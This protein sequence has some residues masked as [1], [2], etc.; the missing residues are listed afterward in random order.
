MK[1]LNVLLAFLVSIALG[2]AI[3]EGG[4]R[5]L[6]RGPDPTPL[7][8]FDPQT[9]WSKRADFKVTR[10]SPEYRATIE[11]NALGLRDDPMA[12]PAKPAGIYRVLAIGDSFT[13]GFS[14]EREDLFVDLLEERW[15]AEGRAVEVV[16]AG[17][18]AWDTAQQAAWLEQNIAEYEPDLVLLFPYE[19]D[20]YWNSQEVYFSAGG[21]RSKP[22]YSASGERVNPTLTDL[23]DR[24]WIQDW[25][26]TQWLYEPDMSAA[27]AHAF[28]PSGAGR[29]IERELGPLLDSPPTW[30]NEVRQHTVGALRAV[31]SAAESVGAEVAVFP[32]PSAALFDEDWI[33]RYE[34]RGLA[35]TRWSADRPVDTFLETAKTAGLEAID[36]RPGLR[37]AAEAAEGPIYFQKTD[38]H[39]NPAG[40]RA[41]AEIVYG[42]L[43]GSNLAPGLP[44]AETAVS[45][46]AAVSPTGSDE[47]GLPTPILIWIVLTVVASIGYRLTYPDEAAWQ[48][49]LKVGAL[50]AVVISIFMGVI[51]LS[52][53]VPPKFQ[54]WIGP[55]FAL[56]VL[57]VVLYYL[58][59]KIL[60]IGEL[61]RSFVMRGHWYLM[62]LLVVLLTIGSLLVVAASNPFVAPFIYTLF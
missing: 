4:L 52:G 12:S 46:M 45:S 14:V 20:L 25:A 39:F 55:G 1:A 44:P 33:G 62:P 22:K 24:T 5:L 9:G 53:A 11:T 10:S 26:L 18:E 32:I 38:W 37:A 40:N 60:T 49:P 28:T 57:G 29:A 19:N 7:V 43:E 34:R 54:A 42:T 23:S 35:G 58:G 27:P 61:L 51:I 6:G 36:T 13:Q 16:N 30:M 15:Q 17:T 41:F 3:L 21:V 48:A 8:E 59:S 50:L 47:G 56:L 31:R 2:L